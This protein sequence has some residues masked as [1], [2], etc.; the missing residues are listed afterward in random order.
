MFAEPS[1]GE[2]RAICIVSQAYAAAMRG[3]EQAS[4]Q[5]GTET[6]ATDPERGLPQ[7]LVA[8][9]VPVPFIS[10]IFLTFQRLQT[11]RPSTQSGLQMNFIGVTH[12]KI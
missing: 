8:L 5:R 11:G 1:P 7:A 10:A 3:Q 12:S 2:P 4:L 9:Q 6:R